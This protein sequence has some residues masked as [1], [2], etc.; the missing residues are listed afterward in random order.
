MT[1]SSRY[2]CTN[3]TWIAVTDRLQTFDNLNG[4][5]PG[6]IA[7]GLRIRGKLY[8]VAQGK[9]I[10]LGIH[11]TNES[12]SIHCSILSKH[13]SLIFFSILSALD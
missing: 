9:E 6:C 12:V 5:T 1:T 8:A 13:R 2:V 10:V 11:G 3:V 7:S 4:K